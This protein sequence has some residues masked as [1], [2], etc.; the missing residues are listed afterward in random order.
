MGSVAENYKCPLCG[1]VGNGGY[2]VDGLSIGPICTGAKFANSCLDKVSGPHYLSPQ[3]IVGKALEKVLCH[4]FQK[5]Y[6]MLIL[7][8]MIVPWLIAVNEDNQT[9]EDPSL[10]ADTQQF[11]V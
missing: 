8:V 7:E 6:P 4:H 11:D 3:K 1:R 5:R 2:D 10:P 9:L